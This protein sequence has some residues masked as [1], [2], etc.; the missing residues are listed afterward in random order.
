MAKA[1]YSPLLGEHIAHNTRSSCGVVRYIGAVA[2]KQG[3][4]I[5]IELAKPEG[6]NDGAVGGQRYFSCQ[7]MVRANPWIRALLLIDSPCASLSPPAPARN[8]DSQHGTFVQSTVFGRLW[9]AAP[10]HGTPAM[11]SSV[12]RLAEATPRD[13]ETMAESPAAAID[14]GASPAEGAVLGRRRRKP[15]SRNP[16]RAASR[17]NS[18]IGETLSFQGVGTRDT[19]ATAE[20]A[21]TVVAAAA[22][23]QAQ[24]DAAASLAGLQ[25]SIARR[26]E[27][28]R[29]IRRLMEGG[30][31]GEA[32]LLWCAVR[33]GAVQLRCRDGRVVH[34]RVRLRQPRGSVGDAVA[35]PV[36]DTE[37]V[38]VV[39]RLIA[40]TPGCLWAADDG[41]VLRVFALPESLGA[42]AV[43]RGQ[44]C[45]DIKDVTLAL[46]DEIAAH[47]KP[48]RALLAVPPPVLASAAASTAAKAG[49]AGS[50]WSVWSSSNDGTIR[51]YCGLTQ[52]LLC[53]VQAAALGNTRVCA[54]ALC[55]HSV[56]GGM[57]ASQG[58]RTAQAQ[59]QRQALVWSG[60]ERGVLR[61][62]API[63]RS[64]GTHRP[65]LQFSVQPLGQLVAHRGAVLALATVQLSATA[66]S[67]APRSL[68]F[69]SSDDGTVR[70]WAQGE[71]GGSAARAGDKGATSWQCMHVLDAPRVAPAEDFN[72]DT[73]GSGAPTDLPPV[74]TTLSALRCTLTGR[75]FVVTGGSGLAPVLWLL[76]SQHCSWS[77]GAVAGGSLA[78]PAPPPPRTLLDPSRGDPR[79]SPTALLLLAHCPGGAEGSSPLAM[80]LWVATSRRGLL[81]LSLDDPAAASVA[82]NATRVLQDRARRWIVRLRFLAW[83]SASRR[84]LSKL[85]AECRRASVVLDGASEDSTAASLDGVSPSSG[86]QALDSVIRDAAERLPW[87]GAHI[88]ALA[89]A[90][91]LRARLAQLPAKVQQ[92]PGSSQKPMII[93]PG[94][95]PDE[96]EA[97]RRAISDARFASAENAFGAMVGVLPSTPESAGPADDAEAQAIVKAELG[98]FDRAPAHAAFVPPAAS[99][100]LD[101]TGASAQLEQARKMA[102]AWKAQAMQLKQELQ[103]GDCAVFAR[104]LL[105]C[106][107]GRLLADAMPPS[108]SM[109]ICIAQTAQ[110]EIKQLQSQL[111]LQAS[112]MVARAETIDH[113]SLQNRVLCASSPQLSTPPKP[114]LAVFSHERLSWALSQSSDLR[115]RLVEMRSVLASAVKREDFSTAAETKVQ[116]GELEAASRA[117]EAEVTAQERLRREDEERL[118]REIEEQARQAAAEQARRE[119]EERARH[120]AEEKA[121]R[122]A[123]ED[124]RRRLAANDEARRRLRADLTA[125][126]ARED[127]GLCVELKASVAELEL[128]ASREREALAALCSEAEAAELR[129]EEQRKRADDAKAK[130]EAEERAAREASARAK[131]REAAES[132]ERA[133]K[134]EARDAAVH[135]SEERARR[136][137]LERA[138]AAADD[139]AAVTLAAERTAAREKV[140]NEEVAAAAAAKRKADADAAAKREA[141]AAVSAA[142]A[143]ESRAASDAEATRAAED[144]AQVEEAAAAQRREE[145]KEGEKQVIVAAARKK[146]EDA[147]A[148]RKTVAEAATKQEAETAERKVVA[149][150]EKREEREVVATAPTTTSKAPSLTME[151]W[152]RDQ[153]E[154]AGPVALPAASSP[155]LPRPPASAA[156]AATPSATKAPPPPPPPRARKSSRAK[157]LK[158]PSVANRGV[159]KVQEAPAESASQASPLAN[160]V[161]KLPASKSQLSLLDGLQAPAAARAPVGPASVTQVR[162]EP[163]ELTARVDVSAGTPG[164]R[165]AAPAAPAACWSGAEERS[166]VVGFFCLVANSP[167][168]RT[169]PR[170]LETT[171]KKLFQTTPTRTHGKAISTC[172]SRRMRCRYWMRC[173][174]LRWRHGETARL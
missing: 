34:L 144:K 19:E 59:A 72:A 96:F 117:A 135:R 41:G 138:K 129:A 174:I 45:S 71:G 63:V 137:S 158:S 35:V 107:F 75:V 112:R 103:V 102:A 58:Q 28:P 55:T 14:A 113:S 43:E 36:G 159:T 151:S 1:V 150:H 108:L 51:C 38:E 105:F 40:L 57:P 142:L 167:F 46:I 134:Q 67:V 73:V 64:Q 95:D 83:L 17:R 100:P 147:A 170:R 141:D 7:P 62:W 126:I 61:A 2:S 30:C 164:H 109:P 143:T 11:A 76:S 53:V 78:P 48:A 93:A 145:E 68:L 82:L 123:V 49:E 130:R 91:E 81:L 132:A 146:D 86:T 140:R 165:P 122:E 136:N 50:G 172:R 66:S 119:A 139:A 24:A 79:G 84:A 149:D 111:Q 18:S 90:R 77:T 162:D 171:P 52:Q 121:R 16:S 168:P 6:R 22:T 65:T 44:A 54:L 31:A 25:V 114:H 152:L 3:T 42:I 26:M 9:S 89:Q 128:E 166:Y 56:S 173:L 157:P 106:L 131:A 85:S 154:E 169:L 39:A 148:A 37:P 161:R 155:S 115:R 32:V 160:F 69:S 94:E 47:R 70:V 12:T 5:G 153:L 21:A 23:E 125:A 87:G 60:D 29:T 124:M 4:W 10:G 127:F 13:S 92:F 101:H 98:L 156:A 15:N 118:R 120:E 80:A 163:S 110:S 99:A 20:A 104:S 27:A 88:P 97:R 8:P 116:L 133:A 33:G 74:L